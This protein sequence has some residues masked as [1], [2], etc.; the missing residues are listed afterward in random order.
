MEAFEQSVV[1]ELDFHEGF[2][3]AGEV[4]TFDFGG[5]GFWGSVHA[6]TKNSADHA[7]IFK[8]DFFTGGKRGYCLKS[9]FLNGIFT[10][11]ILE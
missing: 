8:G 1:F 11:E 9:R 5:L 2:F 4:E 6:V 7:T 10:R 3:T